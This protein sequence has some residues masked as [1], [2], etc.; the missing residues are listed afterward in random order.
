MS[1]TDQH[2]PLTRSQANHDS[3]STM[4]DDTAQASND[5]VQALTGTLQGVRIT[6]R[7]PELPAFDSKNI[8]I[9]LKRVANAYRR[10][11]I[12]DSES[13]FAFIESKFAVDADPRINELLFGGGT[14][15]E[16]TEFEAYLR[17]RYGRTKSQQASV[18]LDGIQRD[19]KLPSEM[20]ALV[21]ERVGSITIDDIIKEMVIREL[22]TDI[23]RTIHDK[24][25]D[26]DGAETVKLADQYFDKN[27]KPIH[28]TS[29]H[30]INAVEE[31]P[32]LIDTDDEDE[33]NEV[34]RRFPNRNRKFRPQQN[35]SR[36]PPSRKPNPQQTS[37][38]RNQK[39]SN[40]PAPSERRTHTGK[41]TVKPSKLCRWHTQF[42]KDA[43][44]CEAGCDKFQGTSS[45]NDKAGRHT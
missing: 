23:R 39:S 6:S 38:P 34:G 45:G 35:Q 43:Y 36:G 40:A 25:K 5:T 26:L 22:P 30:P 37:R 31:I 17:T 13:K 33:V 19:G 29:G 3:A 42:G 44:T 18:V 11:G 32:D 4:G 28:R 8:D 24:A 1:N 16:W 10:A 21:K 20:F 14:P 7:K 12:E 9:W 15:E 2:R 41:S 27:G